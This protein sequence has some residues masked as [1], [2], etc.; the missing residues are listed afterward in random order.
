MAGK[1]LEPLLT[2]DE[3]AALLRRPY[4]IKSTF[5]LTPLNQPFLFLIFSHNIN[6]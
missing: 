6:Y 1:G 4:Q 5:I 3:P 2:G